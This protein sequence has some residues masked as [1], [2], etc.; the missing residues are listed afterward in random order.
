MGRWTLDIH[1]ITRFLILSLKISVSPRTSV[2]YPTVRGAVNAPGLLLDGRV[3]RSDF[4]RDWEITDVLVYMP[5]GA[6]KLVDQCLMPGPQSV[7]YSIVGTR[8]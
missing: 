3:C 7:R 4:A 6:D 8:S 1:Y 5:S 2:R